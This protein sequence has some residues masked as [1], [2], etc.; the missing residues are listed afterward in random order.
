MCQEDQTPVAKVHRHCPSSY[1]HPYAPCMEY[2][3]STFGWFLG[4]MFVNIPWSIWVDRLA[5][6]AG[7]SVLIVFSFAMD[8]SSYEYMEAQSGHG[9]C[10]KMGS[11][12]KIHQ[13]SKHSKILYIIL[14]DNL[15]MFIQTTQFM[16]ELGAFLSHGG[17]PVPSSSSW[18]LTIPWPLIMAIQCY[19]YIVMIQNVITIT[20]WLIPRIVSG[21][22]S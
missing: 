13:N 11:T 22:W 9:P 6:F 10:L 3:L 17:T 18:G 21:L 5:F 4:H 14:Q 16:A 19:S 12:H 15:N 7:E 2:Y 8:N 20:W 1:H